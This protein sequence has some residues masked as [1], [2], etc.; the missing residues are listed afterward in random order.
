MN[1]SLVVMYNVH[2]YSRCL[3]TCSFPVE[4]KDLSMLDSKGFFL[5]VSDLVEKQFKMYYKNTTG[6]S[7]LY[8]LFADESHLLTQF[9]DRK[10]YN[11]QGLITANY[12]GVLQVV[13]I[14]A[15]V[16]Q[17][18]HP[19]SQRWMPKKTIPESFELMQ[20]YLD[21]N[22]AIHVKQ[23]LLPLDMELRRKI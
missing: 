16:V 3:Y 2:N 5:E 14:P 9:R 22:N 7:D 8:W 15:K 23:V 21:G 13:T 11:L 6:G 12:T 4:W 1:N 20:Q 17:G 10:L 19:L 18:R